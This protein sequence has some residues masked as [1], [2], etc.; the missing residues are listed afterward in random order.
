MKLDKDNTISAA[1]FFTSLFIIQYA[2]IVIIKPQCFL[3]R[4]QVSATNETHKLSIVK[5][6]F[7]TLGTTL[8]STVIILY[9]SITLE[10]N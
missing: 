8:L 6:V 1:V 3:Q 7:C 9:F 10:Q 5:T 4:K 2:I